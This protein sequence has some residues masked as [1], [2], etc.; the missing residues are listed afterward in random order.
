MTAKGF[1]FLTLEDETGM[2]QAIVS[3][4]L[5]RHNRDLIVGNPGLI[6]EGH[7]Q[8]GGGQI[9]VRA[10]GFRPLPMEVGVKSHDFH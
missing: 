10:L 8:H 7:L 2:S 5:F 9:S 6:V 1:V 3:P 4:D